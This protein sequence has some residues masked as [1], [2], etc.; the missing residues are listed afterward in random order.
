MKKSELASATRIAEGTVGR[1]TSYSL[2]S[3]GSAEMFPAKN[4][5]LKVI[6]ED[7]TGISTTLKT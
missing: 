5:L 2:G 1:V 6:Q 3:D 7:K 4:K